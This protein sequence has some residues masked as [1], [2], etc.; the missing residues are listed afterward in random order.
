MTGGRSIRA[1]AA[2]LSAGRISALALAEES[3]ALAQRTNPRLKS[4]ITITARQARKQA[5]ESDGR[6]RAGTS[7]GVLDGIS[8]AAK[9]LFQTRGIRTTAG[10]KVLQDWMPD[11]SAALISKLGAAGAV[12]LGKTNLHEFAYGATG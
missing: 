9:D 10:S 8:Y 7:L 3:L 2:D 4:F 12:L 6:R 1:I 11:T 5:A